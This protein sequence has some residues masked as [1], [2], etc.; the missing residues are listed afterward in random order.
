M[1]RIL[2]LNPDFEALSHNETVALFAG[3]RTLAFRGADSAEFCR[4]LVR[5]FD[6][7]RSLD[8]VRQLEPAICARVDALLATDVLVEQTEAPLIS[9]MGETG[10]LLERLREA[11]T[12]FAVQIRSTAPVVVCFPDE[13]GFRLPHQILKCLQP[14]Q[15]LLTGLRRAAS[16][17]VFPLMTTPRKIWPGSRSDCWRP[18]RE[19]E[20]STSPTRFP[21]HRNTRTSERD[22]RIKRRDGL[23][24]IC[25]RSS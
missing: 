15:S 5:L 7:P 6:K 24:L 21:R 4:K 10:S 3:D 12:G 19:S 11:A 25:L 20:T 2:R 18:S 16:L 23:P 1:A 17:F 13:S 9:L 22:S 14:G 8:E